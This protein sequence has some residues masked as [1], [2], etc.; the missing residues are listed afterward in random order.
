MATR[1][2]TVNTDYTLAYLK[3]LAGFRKSAPAAQKFGLTP[4][5]ARIKRGEVD[6]CLRRGSMGWVND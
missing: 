2:N 1:K 3:F 6:I 5:Q 4:E